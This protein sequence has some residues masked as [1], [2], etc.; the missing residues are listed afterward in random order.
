MNEVN[1][2]NG[3][4][5]LLVEDNEGDARLT[6]LGL[7]RKD[8]RM[9]F[10]NVGSR[11]EAL[12]FL[13]G[14]NGGEPMSP[15]LILLSLDLASGEGFRLLEDIKRSPELSLIPT[16]AMAKDMS[17]VEVQRAYAH[18]ANC[19]IIKPDDPDRLADL[20]SK[21]ESFW[22]DTVVLPGGVTR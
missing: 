17:D 14:T 5:V 6:E 8:P 15:S 13:R 22:F 12:E 1:N 21:L 9:G 19:F 7:R 18:Y 3:K 20:V 11:S 2:E 10:V 16:I 4:L